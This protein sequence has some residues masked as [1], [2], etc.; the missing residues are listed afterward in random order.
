MDFF[1]VLLLFY[2]TRLGNRNIPTKHIVQFKNNERINVYNIIYKGEILGNYLEKK[3]GRLH[4]LCKE[5]WNLVGAYLILLKYQCQ[6]RVCYLHHNYTVKCTFV[7]LLHN[8][9]KYLAMFFHISY[10]SILSDFIPI[11]FKLESAI[12]V[13]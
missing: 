6:C 5:K 7:L 13:S 8:Y 1:A 10:R 4:R 3:K 11:L 2:G 12:I 9:K